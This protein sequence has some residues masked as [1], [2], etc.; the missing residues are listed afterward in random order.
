MARTHQIGGWPCSTHRTSWSLLSLYLSIA[1]YLVITL[2]C[3]FP[4]LC[5][6][7]QLRSSMLRAWKCQR[8]GLASP[9]FLSPTLPCAYDSRGA[10][11]RERTIPYASTIEGSDQ[12]LR[13]ETYSVVI[14][15]GGCKGALYFARANTLPR[16]HAQPAPACLPAVTPTRSAHPPPPHPHS[17]GGDSSYHSFRATFRRHERQLPSRPTQQKRRALSDG[18]VRGR[19]RWPGLLGAA[20]QAAQGVACA[21]P[22]AAPP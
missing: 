14:G 11:S 18:R 4:L 20:E 21:S 9:P 6:P 2:S 1:S 3:S 10:R 7:T 22:T 12:R 16:P 13:A 19:D 15:G 17:L 5:A 8:Y